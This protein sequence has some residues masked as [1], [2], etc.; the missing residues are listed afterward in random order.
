MGS[1]GGRQVAESLSRWK[2]NTQEEG[3][4]PKGKG[5]KVELRLDYAPLATPGQGS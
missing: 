4:H 5:V 1:E 3:N 2:M